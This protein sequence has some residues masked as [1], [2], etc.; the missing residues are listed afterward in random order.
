[1][2]LKHTPDDS[3][4]KTMIPKIVLMIK[5]FLA[6]VNLES[7]NTENRFNLAQL[8]NQLMFKPGEEVVCTHLNNLLSGGTNSCG[9]D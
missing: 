3:S 7:G 5:E 2:V 1:M 9:L 4:D 6:S 8:D